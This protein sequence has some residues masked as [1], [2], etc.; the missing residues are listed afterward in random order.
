MNLHI[1]IRIN[2]NLTF[3]FLGKAFWCGIFLL[4]G[5]SYGQVYQKG[6]TLISVTNGASI[7]IVQ[8]STKNISKGHLVLKND[9]KIYNADLLTNVEIVYQN[10]P[11]KQKLQQPTKKTS[12][13]QKTAMVSKTTLKPKSKEFFLP[14]PPSSN[15]FLSGGNNSI[16]ATITHPSK[17]K[18][19][20]F[21][22]RGNINYKG[23]FE[24]TSK[25]YTYPHFHSEKQTKWLF[26]RP[27]PVSSVEYP[28]F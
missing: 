26:T 15:S 23:R 11:V 4:A 7:F 22:S 27:P 3:S 21:F 16:S 19:A 28:T 12:V 5:L 17:L 6:N 25:I 8:D 20:V 13:Q 10:P 2:R 9:V 24:I 1:R 18:D 14:L